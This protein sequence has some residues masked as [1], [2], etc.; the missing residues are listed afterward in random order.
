MGYRMI[1]G[2]SL[3]ASGC[4]SALRATAMNISSGNSGGRACTRFGASIISNLQ[5]AK[6]KPPKMP[7][8]GSDGLTPFWG[9]F[10]ARARMK[11]NPKTPLTRHSR[12]AQY[13]RW[14]QPV[15]TRPTGNVFCAKSQSSQ[16]F[17]PLTLRF[18]RS[19]NLI[20]R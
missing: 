8:Y 17:L 1:Y 20:P 5:K 9:S 13:P 10:Y 16:Y 12:H 18:W 15:S 2:A 11:I 4:V 19:R 3:F 14:F 7:C 6:Q